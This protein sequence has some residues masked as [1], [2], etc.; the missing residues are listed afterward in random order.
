M[1]PLSRFLLA[2]L[3]FDTRFVLQFLWRTSVYFLRRRVFSVG[4]WRERL[5]WLPKLLREE[6]VALGG[7]DEAAVRALKKLR[8]VQY[9]IVGHSHGPRFHAISRPT[10]VAI[11]R[12]P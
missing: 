7:Y 8:G 12:M 6:V 2:A 4:A 11:S 10:P 1:Q 5:R 9:L 3:L